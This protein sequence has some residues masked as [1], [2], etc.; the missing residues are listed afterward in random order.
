MRKERKE[1]MGILMDFYSE[2]GVS[3]TEAMDLIEELYGVDTLSAPLEIR[4]QQLVDS[5]RPFVEE[6]GRDAANGFCKYWLQISPKGRKFKFEKEKTWNLKLR[7]S[8][9]MKNQT[10][11][12]IINAMTK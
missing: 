5:V 10:K 7:I 4:R 8:T 6:M 2:D 9:W 12:T 11:W 3:V 1:L